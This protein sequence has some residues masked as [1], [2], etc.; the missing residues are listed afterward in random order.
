MNTSSTIE[1]KNE[2]GTWQNTL[3][4]TYQKKISQYLS[5]A[6]SIVQRVLVYKAPSKT[7]TGFQL[8][9]SV[10]HGQFGEGHVISHSPDGRLLVRFKGAEKSRWVFHS[11]LSRC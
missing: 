2:F 7:F 11:F 4:P 6:L 9:Q 3:R 8:G 1:L 10:Y 5:T